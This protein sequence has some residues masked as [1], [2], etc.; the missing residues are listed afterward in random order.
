VSWISDEIEARGGELS[1]RDFMELALYDPTRGYYCAAE[2]RFG[3]RGDFLTAPA[4][5]RWYGAVLAALV[6]RLAGDCGPITLVDVGSGD[7]ALF[8]QLAASVRRGGLREVISIEASATMR[9]LQGRRAEHLPTRFLCAPDLAEAPPFL[10]PVVVHAS[11]LYDAMPVHRV[12]MRDHGLAELWIRSDGAVLSW[13]ERAASRELEEYFEGH[14]VSLGPNQ[15]AE[16]N[17][18]ARPHHLELLQRAGTDGLCMI[19]DYGYPARRLYDSRARHQGSLACY[20][21]HRL[22]RDPL[23]APGDS[24]ITAHVNWDD[25]QHAAREAGWSDLGIWPLAEFMVRAGLEGV[26][27]DREV[28]PEA[29]LDAHTVAERQEIK[30]LLDPD[31]MG[32]DLTMLV[33]ASGRMAD[34]ARALLDA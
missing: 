27:E 10:S 18:G 11:E 5:S 23:E 29:E 32:S 28:G 31:G 33:Q 13:Q 16:A 2:P 9:A 25:L 19:L 3:R 1:F 4:A 17:L 24:D 30:R 20:R 21:E 15:L 6:E 7:G 14:R 34:A 12:V 8:E 22:S 26:M